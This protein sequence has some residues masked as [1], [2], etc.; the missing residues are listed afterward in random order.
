MA[1]NLSLAPLSSL[2][3]PPFNRL[4]AYPSGDPDEVESRIHQLHQLEITALDFQGPLRTDRLSVLG[5]GVVGIVVI[6]V[7]G[8]RRIAVKIRRVDARRPSLIHE[9]E[10]LMAANSLKVGPECLGGTADVL[11]MEFIEGLSLPL[12][13]ESLTGRGR[14]ARVRSVVKPLLEECF[15]MDAY[16][17]DH[18][19][20]SRAHKNVI[21][22]D[23]G[24]RILDFESASLVR[25]PS[26]FTSLTQY[27]FLGGS[28]AKKI[29]K[30][31]GPVDRDELLKCLRDYKAGGWKDAFEEATRILCLN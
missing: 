30:V 20:L 21:V 14:R 17:L 26:N 9:A 22:S 31:L 15:R 5:K 27:L 13:L 1:E 7:R 24:A 19:E 8:N 28:I 29:A 6:G 11:A 12:W 25:R 3:N 23:D 4:V 10:L 2:A 18:G 16:G